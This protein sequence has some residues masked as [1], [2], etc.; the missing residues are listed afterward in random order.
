MKVVIFGSRTFESEEAKKQ[1]DRI[2]SKFIEE[3][4]DRIE[5]IIC[6]SIRGACA[7]GR[8]IALAKQIRV[9]EYPYEKGKG[10]YE[11]LRSIVIRSKAIVDQGDYFLLFHD[12]K[13]KGTMHD[14]DMIKK[15]KKPYEYY[16]IEINE[17]ELKRREEEKQWK[18]Y[19]K[20]FKA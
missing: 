1:I 7:I 14:L 2:L 17:E 15:A 18:K 10:R 20:G 11:A 19:F 12:G 5:Y 6:P 3:N 13:S 8:E 4:I 9:M 16:H